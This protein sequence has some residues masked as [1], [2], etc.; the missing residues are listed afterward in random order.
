MARYAS[1]RK[2]WG[3]SDRSG[4]RY[5][6]RDMIKEW[7]GLKVGIDE[8]EPK[9]PQLEPNYPGPDPTALYEPRPD[10][11]SE[12]TVERL[13]TLNPFLSGSSGS[14]GITV[15]EKSHG[16]FVVCDFVCPT[17]RTRAEFD[18]DIT[19]W[20]DTIKQGRFEDTNKIFEKPRNVTFH[21][22]EWNDKNHMN[23]AYEIKEKYV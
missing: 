5:R 6:L 15:I 3:Y 10:S 21:I 7:N 8:Y 12:V 2:S 17:K 16:R 9:H 22:T 1:G 19:I 14:A 20:M 23:I 4:F 11:R 13:L 18:A